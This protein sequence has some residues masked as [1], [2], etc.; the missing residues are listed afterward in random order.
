M[1]T[2]EHNKNNS[3]IA[4]SILPDWANERLRLDPWTLPHR[5][6]LERSGASWTIDRQGAVLKR[7]LSCGLP[8]SMSIPA[9]AFKGVA[10]R[11]MEQEDGSVSVTL[12]LHH[13]DPQLCAPLLA[14]TD[15]EDAA[16]DWH[17]WSRLMGLPMLIVGTDSIARPVVERLGQVMVEAP[18]QR[19][20]RW[21]MLKHRPWFLRRRKTGFI[22]PVVRVSGEEL[23]GGGW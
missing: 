7:K 3:R 23:F 16:A 20:K 21:G 13:H 15:L 17:A 8:M 6:R 9:R 2:V 1:N 4:L 12:E 14:A 22:G 19:R 18:L 11:A 10:A 5:I